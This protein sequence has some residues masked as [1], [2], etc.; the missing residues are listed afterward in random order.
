[1]ASG[2]Q[3]LRFMY[4]KNTKSDTE[5]VDNPVESAKL[6]GLRYVTDRS[7]GISRKRNGKGFTYLGVDERPIRDEQQLQRIKSLVIP[8]AWKDVWICPSP[9]GHI[10]ATA[11]DAKGRKQYRYH[12]RWREKRDETK[13][14]RM[15]SFAQ[16]LPGIR[17]RVEADLAL[18]GLP[19][20]KV[21]AT[22]VRL[23]ETTFIRI[24][25]QEYAR[26]NNSFGL[27]TMR[28]R[29][30]A[31]SGSTLRFQFRGKS[32]KH[33]QIAI[34]NPQMAKIIRHC[35]DMPG[36]ELFQ[37][38]GDDGELQ[39]IGSAEVNQY[40]R[41]ISGQDFTAKDFRTWA[42][43]VL[44]ALTLKEL[45]EF[46]SETQAKKNIVEAVQAV[47]TRLGNTPAICRK[48]YVHPM[49]LDAYLDH[50][51]LAGLKTKRTNGAKGLP[52]LRA[53]EKAVMKLLKQTLKSKKKSK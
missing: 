13:Y 39:S 15:L 12:A 24:G 42:G 41:E 46:D 6:A 3:T 8:P 51:L 30:V 10:Q 17:K 4:Q 28:N 21:L 23:L 40:L 43:T 34:T 32:G 35:Q 18:P 48:C 53:E 52:D 11:R 37:Y 36:Q 33:H 26:T 38:V 31:V 50:S 16:A 27:T 1:M 9:N 2:L 45:G 29:H 44:A 25:N 14:S 19:Q 5:L 47:A 49:V 22:I 7:P 20:A